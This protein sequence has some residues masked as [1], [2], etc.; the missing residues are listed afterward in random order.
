LNVAVNNLTELAKTVVD[1]TPDSKLNEAKLVGD[2]A[3]NVFVPVYDWQQRIF[4][5]GNI[6][7]I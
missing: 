4:N 2:T 6:Y 7:T 3:G 1:S 5:V